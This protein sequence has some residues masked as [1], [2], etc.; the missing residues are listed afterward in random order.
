MFALF[1]RGSNHNMAL[2]VGNILVLISHCSV[3]E[4]GL[5]EDRESVTLR[6]RERE[7]VSVDHKKKSVIQILLVKTEDCFD[8]STSF[9]LC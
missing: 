1:S 5:L 2:C 4:C 7:S 3:S 6:E 8:L 9:F